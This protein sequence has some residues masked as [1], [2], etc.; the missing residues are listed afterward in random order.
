MRTILALV[1][2]TSACAAEDPERTQQGTICQTCPPPD[3]TSPACPVGGSTVI[4]WNPT[5]WAKVVGYNNNHPPTQVIF[6]SATTGYYCGQE[7]YPPDQY[8]TPDPNDPRPW[9][10]P[11]PTWWRFPVC[12]YCAGGWEA[13]QAFPADSKTSSGTYAQQTAQSCMY[14]CKGK[15]FCESYPRQDGAWQCNAGPLGPSN[16]RTW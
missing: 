1:L 7:S 3:S 8:W 4:R 9:I 16:C 5:K 12:A 10:T 15:S 13:H 2:A 6:S 11:K 14:V